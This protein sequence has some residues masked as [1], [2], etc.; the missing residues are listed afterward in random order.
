MT[1][2]RILITGASGSIGH[3][4]TEALI[5]ETN[6]ELY[7]LVRSPNKLRLDTRSR[8][9][10]TVL[11]G[12]MREINRFA[13][14]LKTINV[15]VHAASEWGGPGAFDIN[16]SKT[17]ELLNLL[18]PATCQQVIYFSTASI[19]DRKNQPLKEAAELGTYYIRSK[20]DCLRRLPG[21]ALAPRITILF[22]T[23]VVG[24]DAQ[25][26]YSFLS[27]GLPKLAKW[28]N[29]IRFLRFDG[30]FHFIHGRDVAQIVCHLIDHPATGNGPRSFVLGQERSTVN[31][32]VEEVCAYLDKKIYFRIPLPLSLAKLLIVLSQQRILPPDRAW[33]R[34]CLIYRH[35][36]H[37]N[38]TSPVSFGLPNFCPTLTDV[39]RMSGIP[40]GSAA[41]RPLDVSAEP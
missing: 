17:L 22:P 20:Y 4:V 16:V 5:Q 21:V 11:P 7:L 27:D 10:I 25:K 38:P 2:R 6:L 18:D 12:D 3:Y 28:M 26:P 24:G 40:R 29:L 33:D 8:P 35:F 37:E 19:L 36:T 32:A 41:S 31:Q 13:D 9:G 1:P 39:L 23:L 14:L 34:F 15:A 30:S